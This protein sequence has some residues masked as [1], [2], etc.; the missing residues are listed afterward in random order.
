[1]ET[2]EVT[3]T[4]REPIDLAALTSDAFENLLRAAGIERPFDWQ[5]EA[6]GRIR[7]TFSHEAGDAERAVGASERIANDLGVGN[8]EVRVEPSG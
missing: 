8:W 3:L 6:D 4:S 7:V 2:V 5:Q 1:M